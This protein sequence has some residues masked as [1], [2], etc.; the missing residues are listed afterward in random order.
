MQGFLQLVTPTLRYLSSVAS[1]VRLNAISCPLLSCSA[2][3]PD[4]FSILMPLATRGIPALRSYES[5]RLLL[6]T[7]ST[8]AKSS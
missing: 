7:P 6:P 8:A 2:T 1:D 5:A 4:I 3:T